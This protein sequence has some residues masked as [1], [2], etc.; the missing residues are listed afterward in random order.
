MIK[1]RLLDKD[2]GYRQRD[3]SEKIP[4]RQEVLLNQYWTVRVL[5]YH[6][7]PGRGG[8]LSISEVRPHALVDFL[9][10]T[11]VTGNETD[12]RR[13]LV[14]RRC[15]S[16]N[17]GQSECSGTT[18]GLIKEVPFVRWSDG[19][20]LGGL[21]L[22]VSDYIGAKRTTNSYSTLKMALETSKA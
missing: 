19:L 15:Y 9:I 12:L 6:K 7:R 8:T 20:S 4:R 17:L 13:F 11:S 2:F 3:R 21:R 10:K 14:V 1:T 22:N 5:W 18:R 16:I